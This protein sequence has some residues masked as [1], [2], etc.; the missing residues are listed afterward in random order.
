M[1]VKLVYFFYFFLKFYGHNR[2]SVYEAMGSNL[3]CHKS[4]IKEECFK[5][6]RW[7]Q[8]PAHDDTL[9]LLIIKHI[10]AIPW[11]HFDVSVID[12]ID[13]SWSRQKL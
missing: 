12:V 13:G 11:F 3:K 8:F 5:M 6:T 1:R 4:C 7:Q 2:P 10:N 9:S